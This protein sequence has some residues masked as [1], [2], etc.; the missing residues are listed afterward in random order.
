MA[1]G[2]SENPR[3]RGKALAEIDN[4]QVDNK[5]RAENNQEGGAEQGEGCA[6][7]IF[8]EEFSHTALLCN[9]EG[10]GVVAHASTTPRFLFKDKR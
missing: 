3:P 1:P 5:D 2:C 10:R 9:K 7:V 6:L 8:G 4:Q